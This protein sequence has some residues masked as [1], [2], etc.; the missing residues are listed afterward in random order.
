MTRA[1][2]AVH[3]YYADR[4]GLTEEAAAALVT[5]EDRRRLTPAMHARR[6]VE[7]LAA[8]GLLRAALARHTGR[9]ASSL[10]IEATAAGKPLCVGGPAVSVSHSGELLVC[11]L[12]DSGAVGVDV[13]TRVPR[14]SLA[15][16]A[17][18]FFAPAEAR[19]LAAEP[20]ARFR[21]LWV[22]K[23]AHLKARGVGLAGGL[24]SLE[25]R[26][27]PP[28]LV[29][30]TRDGTPAPQLGLFLGSGCYVGAAVLGAPADVGFEV[31]RLAL[32]DGAD[33]MGP[34]QLLARTAAA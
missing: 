10:R 5:A 23:E 22:L 12:A 32:G 9:A 31:Q 1:A 19:W 14:Q 6:R 17:E 3:V 8:R 28:S 2:H 11:A 26:V 20:D 18:R 21:M 33:A 25:C 13:E 27:E 34:L 24:S 16:I 15:T 29:A 30:A 7:L 4:R